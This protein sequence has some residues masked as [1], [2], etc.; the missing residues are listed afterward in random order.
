MAS[1]HLLHQ[2]KQTVNCDTLFANA[3]AF[4][5]PKIDTINFLFAIVLT[6]FF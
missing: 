3:P 4:G 6:H 1:E 2:R 5:G